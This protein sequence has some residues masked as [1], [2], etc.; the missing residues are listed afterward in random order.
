MS[1]RVAIVTGGASGIGRAIAEAL[2]HGGDRVVVAD[3]NEAEGKGVA[4]TI[5][6]YFVRAD[7]SQRTDCKRLVDETRGSLRWGPHSDQ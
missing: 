4:D 2:A 6:G 1:E 7:L 5:D 3:L